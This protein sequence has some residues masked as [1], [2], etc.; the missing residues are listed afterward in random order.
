MARALLGR[1]AAVL[2]AVAVVLAAGAA[3]PPATTRPG[4]FFPYQPDIRPAPVVFVVF[5]E[6]PLASLLDGRGGIDDERFPGFARL[7]S[8]STWYRNATTPQTFTKE[9]L[10]ALLTGTY[11]VRQVHVT[12][13]YPRNL[14]SLLGRTHEI[15]ASDV[16]ANLC[17]P[18]LCDAPVRPPP[19]PR[20]LGFGPGERGSLFFSFLDALEPPDRPRLHFVHLVLPHGPWR[21]LPSGQRY[22]EVDPMP[23]ETD[24]RGRGTS[25]VP[26]RWLVA[27]AYQRHLLQTRLVDRL[28]SKLIVRL[29]RTGLLHEAL[30]V[31]TADHG[32]GW[33]PGLPKRLPHERTVATLAAVPLFVKA[34]GQ[35][36][37][38][39]SDVP[40]ETVDVL[41]TVADILNARTW[42]GVEG[43][44]LWADVPPPDR[45]RRVVDVPIVAL[46][47]R[48]RH[49]VETRQDLVGDDLWNVAPGRSEELVGLSRADLTIVRGTG[50]TA[51]STAVERL[52]RAD[53][54]GRAFPALFEGILEGVPDG[55][56]PRVAVM[57]EGTIAAVTRSFDWHGLQWFTAILRPGLFG[58][59]EEK[60]R[61]FVV[62]DVAGRTLTRVAIE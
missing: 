23:G 2:L 26:D 30:V 42:P 27:Q 44:S 36:A 54:K 3:A 25:W 58:D 12:F 46:R 35:T 13:D 21:Y 18:D 7:A 20:L 43:I 38:R 11:P 29:R 22:D 55:R 57:V 40:A 45:A 34:P 37:G 47:R 56:R 16:P 4:P 33:V 62:D 39:V 51:K 24:R 41:P 1:S 53:P 48:L 52:V 5:D 14:F 49:A 17:P 9:A 19:G 50:V 10:P 31:V 32:L 15:R 28:V 8:I 60:I 59:G 6:L 61:L